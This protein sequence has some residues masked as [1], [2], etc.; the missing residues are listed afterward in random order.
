VLYPLSYG[1]IWSRVPGAHEYRHASPPAPDTRQ[2]YRQM[3]LSD[4]LH[5]TPF[6]LV[7]AG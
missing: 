3:M 4:D 7:K 1:A 6:R 2:I 5:C